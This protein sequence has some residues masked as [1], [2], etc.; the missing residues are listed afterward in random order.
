[1]LHKLLVISVSRQWQGDAP[2]GGGI[3]LNLVHE[4]RHL[5]GVHSA[6]ATDDRVTLAAE[7]GLTFQELAAVIIVPVLLLRSGI[8]FHALEPHPHESVLAYCSR[9]G[10][11]LDG[12]CINPVTEL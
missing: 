5:Y 11:A 3:G 1:M 12:E 4:I 7:S 8:F 9:L 6:C 10:L 2:F